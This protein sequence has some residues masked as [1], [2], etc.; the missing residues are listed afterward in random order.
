M[1]EPAADFGARFA[2]ELARLTEGRLTSGQAEQLSRMSMDSLVQ[3]VASKL[4][5]LGSDS[6]ELLALRGPEE[7]ARAVVRE[8]VREAG[9]PRDPADR[10]WWLAGLLDILN[11]AH[12]L[13]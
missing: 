10:I 13:Q 1:A 6:V 8:Q 4:S 3:N 9:E 5:W 7:F 11:I 2:T 12:L